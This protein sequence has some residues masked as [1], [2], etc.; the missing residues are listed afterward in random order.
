MKSRVY[1]VESRSKDPNYGYGPCEGW[2]ETGTF[3]AAYKRITD[4]SGRLWKGAYSPG[5]GIETPDGK[6]RIVRD[7]A[8]V[9]VDMRRRHGSIVTG[10]YRE[11]TY[12]KL[13]AKDVDQRVFTRAGFIRFCK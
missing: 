7:C 5:E 9:Q 6:F 4:P 3:L 10:P 13:F 12:R 8:W 11:G 2:V 1:V